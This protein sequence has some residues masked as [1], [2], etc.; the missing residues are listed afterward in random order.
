MTNAL[1]MYHHH[2]ASASRISD[3]DSG[4][5]ARVLPGKNGESGPVGNSIIP[6]AGRRN[7]RPDLR[8]DAIILKGTISHPHRHVAGSLEVC[9]SQIR[10][11]RCLTSPAFLRR[12]LP[13]LAHPSPPRP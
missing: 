12:V 7:K 10:R 13:A 9:K 2:L 4:R 11:A 5:R 3:S 1:C 8:R 6:L